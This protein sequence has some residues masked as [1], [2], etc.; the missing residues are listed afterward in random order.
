M[1]GKVARRLRKEAEDETIGKTKEE[2]RKIYR[3]KKK[4]YK[5]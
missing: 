5:S 3:I 1:R 2:T 4:H